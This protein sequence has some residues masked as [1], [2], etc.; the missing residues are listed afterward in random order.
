[1]PNVSRSTGI[2]PNRPFRESRLLG[3]G[4]DLF[5]SSRLSYNRGM[6]ANAPGLATEI[7][8]VEETLRLRMRRTRVLLLIVVPVVA[9]LF[10]RLYYGNTGVLFLLH[11]LAALGVGLILLAVHQLALKQRPV[12]EV[13]KDPGEVFEYFVSL[14]RGLVFFNQDGVF[15]ENTRNFWP[16]SGP[17]IRVLG[18]D[19]LREV[20]LLR[21]KLAGLMVGPTGRVHL[22]LPDVIPIRLPEGFE[23]ARAERLVETVKARTPSS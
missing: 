21:L 6:T 4:E 19:Y 17:R 13:L 3:V 8:R 2:D 20:R 5:S 9:A 12:F 15:I 11:G 18:L 22:G 23:P 16:Y 1:M 14:N 7:A 10:S